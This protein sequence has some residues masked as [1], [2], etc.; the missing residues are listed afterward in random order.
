[1]DKQDDKKVSPAYVPHKT[2]SNFISSLKESGAPSQ[3]DRSVLKSMSGSDQSAIIQSL[4][5]LSLINDKGIP[6]KE[7]IQLIDSTEEQRPA[8]LR[9]VLEKAY[10]FLFAGSIDLKKATTKQVEDAF[11]DQ[12]VTGSTVVKCI[13]F[14]LA[15]AKAAGITV[16]PHVKTPAP[17]RSATSKPKAAA[18]G[19]GDKAATAAVAQ[20]PPEGMKQIKIQLMDKPD[21]VLLVPSSF[22]ANDWAFLEPILKAYINRML[23]GG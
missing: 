2:F 17:V 10:T 4:K 3:I 21:V 16:S 23:K 19:V 11:R 1:M 15:A 8:L 18:A 7:F 22:D 20:A 6:S 14:F 5:F 9:P 12:G 13:A